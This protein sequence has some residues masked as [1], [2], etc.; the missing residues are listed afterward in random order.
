VLLALCAGVEVVD[1]VALGCDL[2]TVTVGLTV[3][4]DAVALCVTVG[5]FAG[6]IVATGVPTDGTT[7]VTAAVVV[8]AAA[9]VITGV[10]FRVA[11]VAIVPPTIST[12]TAEPPRTS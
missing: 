4:T 12:K 11:S 8:V 5:V 3:G 6:A 2:M 10:G 9:G 1:A 7:D